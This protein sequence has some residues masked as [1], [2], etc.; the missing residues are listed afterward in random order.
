MSVWDFSLIFGTMHQDSVEQVDVE[1]F[2]NVYVSP[3]QAK[4][5][6]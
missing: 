5:A 6:L 3:Q 4:G 1:N 2:Q